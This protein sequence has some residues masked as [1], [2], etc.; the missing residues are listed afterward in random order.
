MIIQCCDICKKPEVTFR[1]KH[2]NVWGSISF[3]EKKYRR[4]VFFFADTWTE[5][6]TVCGRCRA[7]LA[8]A[9]EKEEE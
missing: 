2:G 4:K 6:I 7:A 8:K 5:Y 1:D 3:Q 9:R